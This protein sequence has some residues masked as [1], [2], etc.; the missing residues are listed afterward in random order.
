MRNS[1]KALFA[2]L[3][4]AVGMFS[5]ETQALEVNDHL[6]LDAIKTEL[7]AESQRVVIMANQFVKSGKSQAAVVFTTDKDGRVGYEL[8]SDQPLGTPATSYTV[9][10]KLTN[11]HLNYDKTPP[12]VIL[13]GIDPATAKAQCK[14]FVDDGALGPG[15]C[16]PLDEVIAANAKSGARILLWGNLD[17]ATKL[18]VSALFNDNSVAAKSDIPLNGGCVL[19]STNGATYLGGTFR[20]VATNDTF[21][22]FLR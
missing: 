21:K 14:K 8:R 20:D 15:T 7:N 12:D 10:E 17:K 18:I 5:H 3:L 13:E 9:L 22:D 11:V 1:L 4:G 2:A 19:V 16:K 6:P